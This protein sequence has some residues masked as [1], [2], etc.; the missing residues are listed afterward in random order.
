MAAH[1][2][3]NPK[4]KELGVD[5]PFD[6]ETGEFREDV[7]RRWL[8]WDPVRMVEKYEE[9]LR[10]LKF[11]YIDCGTKDEFNLY[12]GSRILHSKLTAKKIKHYYEEFD[13]GHMNVQYRY[14]TSL[15]MLYEA[16]LLNYRPTS[17]CRASRKPSPSRLNPAATMTIITAGV[18]ASHGALN[19]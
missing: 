8:E 12:W 17:L 14:D 9:N 3:P 7:W 11:I 2:S 15:P 4:S 6:W 10:K 13:D 1:Y 16:L 19:R 18:R 5:L